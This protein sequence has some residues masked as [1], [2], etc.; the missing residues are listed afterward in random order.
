M[1]TAQGARLDSPKQLR[2]PYELLGRTLELIN[3]QGAGV[4]HVSVQAAT[5]SPAPTARKSRAAVSKDK[6]TQP[7]PSKQRR[8]RAS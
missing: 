2:V 1:R 3:H 7:A 5:S 4:Q 6:Q 8:T